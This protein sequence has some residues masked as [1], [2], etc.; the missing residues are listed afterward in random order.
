MLN[1]ETGVYSLESREYRRILSRYA[2]PHRVK[3]GM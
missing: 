2:D 1:L 3:D